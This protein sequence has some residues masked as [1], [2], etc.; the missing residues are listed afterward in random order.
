SDVSWDGGPRDGSRYWEL[1]AGPT[2]AFKWRALTVDAL[3][4]EYAPMHMVGFG[5]TAMLLVAYGQ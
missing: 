2:L 4:G 5:P 3:V 1:T